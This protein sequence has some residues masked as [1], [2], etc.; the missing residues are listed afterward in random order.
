LPRKPNIIFDKRQYLSANIRYDA[1]WSLID[2]TLYRLCRE[3]PNH[4]SRPSVFA[5]V[6]II[7]RSYQ[8]GVGSLVV[9]RGVQGSPISQVAECLLKHGKT[10][11]KWIG[12]LSGDIGPADLRA[13]VDVHGRILNLLKPITRKWK[14]PRSFVSKY[15]HF[16][17]PAV[18]AYDSYAESSLNGL[19]PWDE[20]LN[21][22][23]APRAADHE[24]DRYVKRVLRLFS[25]LEKKELIVSVKHL[26]HYLLWIADKDALPLSP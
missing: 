25:V 13:I 22:F 15:L 1:E 19:V 21:V 11:D 4:S 10:L 20:T 18:P 2:E 7:G 17:N 3:N 23:D 14:S 16:H 9:T 8:T 24:Y 6:F 5:K 26:N 12:A